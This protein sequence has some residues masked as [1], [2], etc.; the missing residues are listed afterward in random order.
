MK[1]RIIIGTIFL[2]GGT[3]IVGMI[4]IFP[5]ANI[6]LTIIALTLIFTALLIYAGIIKMR[7]KDDKA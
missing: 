6:P 7:G 5:K 4:K 1:T 3:L 2:I